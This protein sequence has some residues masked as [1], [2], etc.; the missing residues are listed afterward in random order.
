MLNLG[1]ILLM[2]VYYQEDG[3]W[4][5]WNFIKGMPARGRMTR[6]EFVGTLTLGRQLGFL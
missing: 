3:F 1:T 2:E 6:A 5:N 4:Q